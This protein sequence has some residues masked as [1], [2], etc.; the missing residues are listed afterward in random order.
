MHE[1][2]IKIDITYKQKMKEIC[3]EYARN[4][5]VSQ[6]VFGFLSYIVNA[7]SQSHFPASTESLYASFGRSRDEEPHHLTHWQ[8]PVESPSLQKG[9][10]DCGTATTVICDVMAYESADPGPAASAG[11]RPL[12]AAAAA[13]A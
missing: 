1:I 6:Y 7:F 11:R 10:A 12:S 2:C 3:K 13:A 5:H 9:R 4:I 8:P